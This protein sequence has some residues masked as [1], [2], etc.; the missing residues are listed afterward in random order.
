M[1][2]LVGGD[3]LRRNLLVEDFQ[4]FNFRKFNSRMQ[5]KRILSRPDLDPELLSSEVEAF[6]FNFQRDSYFPPEKIAVEL[7]PTVESRCYGII[8]WIRF[9]TGDVIYE[10]HPSHKSKVL[11]WRQCVHLFD[12]PIDIHPNQSIKITAA[13]NRVNVFF[14]R[15]S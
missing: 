14:L 10:N 12:D 4:E 3:N 1:I 7:Q 2:A 11:G 9:E 8:Q 5:R 6:R 13:H 15:E